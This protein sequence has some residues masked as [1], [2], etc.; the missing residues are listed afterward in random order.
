MNSN[1]SVPADVVF[2]SAGLGNSPVARMSR[3][4]YFVFQTASSL[5]Q[6]K[7]HRTPNPTTTS[8]ERDKDRGSVSWMNYGV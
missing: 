4:S 5:N 3:L 8:A 1:N 7:L 2:R 6:E